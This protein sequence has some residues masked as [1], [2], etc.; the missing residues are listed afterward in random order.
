MDGDDGESSVPEEGGEEVYAMLEASVDG[1]LSQNDDA[2]AAHRALLE[3]GFSGAEAREEIAR[4]LLAVMMHVGRQSERL[5]AAGGG[6]A[7]R[8]EAFQRL[9]G[10]DTVDEIFG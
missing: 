3:R 2:R 4:V 1:V 7:L 6:A 9:A 8:R 5:E 10:G